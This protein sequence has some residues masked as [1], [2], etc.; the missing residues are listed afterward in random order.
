M[1][2]ILLAWALVW[3]TEF[4]WE[5]LFEWCKVPWNWMHFAVGVLY[6]NMYIDSFQKCLLQFFLQSA[7]WL[8]NLF[9]ATRLRFHHFLWWKCLVVKT[10][11]DILVHGLLL[12]CFHSSID[13]LGLL[14]FFYEQYWS[15][16]LQSSAWIPD[17][18]TDHVTPKHISQQIYL[19]IHSKY[20]FIV[21]KC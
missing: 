13:L 17:R 4:P 10:M 7:P 14:F 18:N 20:A 15:V 9:S 11:D 5:M 3:L 12:F 8:N 19:L 21:A 16:I 2:C 1:E 6:Q